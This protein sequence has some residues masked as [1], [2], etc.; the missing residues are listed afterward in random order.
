MQY[1]EVKELIE[2]FEKTDLND[3]EVQLGDARIRLNRSA[4]SPWGTPSPVPQP[5]MMPMQAPSVPQPASVPTGQAGEV[6]RTPEKPS[7]A[8][9]EDDAAGQKVIKSPIVGTFYQSAAPDQAPFVKVGDSVSA[10][11]VVCI[12]EAMKF[13]NEVNA[14]ISGTVAEILVADGEFVEYGQELFRLK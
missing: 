8:A 3:M 10:G 14:E 2:I 9:A 1:S 12:I 13:M 11:D 7:A 5:S 4:V 6:M